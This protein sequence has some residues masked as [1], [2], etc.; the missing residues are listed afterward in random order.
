MP[1]ENHSYIRKEDIIFGLLNKTT[2]RG[3]HLHSAEID[4]TSHF[5]QRMKPCDTRS[6]QATGLKQPDVQKTAF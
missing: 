3:A 4:K 6:F 5:C 1:I 2:F